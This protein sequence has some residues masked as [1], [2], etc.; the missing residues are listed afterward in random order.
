M[1]N[2]RDRAWRRFKSKVNKKRGMSSKEKWKPEKKWKLVY[3]RSA[4]LSRA[5]QLGF[6]YPRKNIRQLLEIELFTDE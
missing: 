3:L 2:I 6:E 4:K 1:T 5:K